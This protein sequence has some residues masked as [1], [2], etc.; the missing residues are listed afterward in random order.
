MSTVSGNYSTG[1][2]STSSTTSTSTGVITGSTVIP[3]PYPV[4]Y[5]EHHGFV[6]GI[7]DAGTTFNNEATTP[8]TLTNGATS[9]SFPVPGGT[10]HWEFVNPTPAPPP[11][12]VPSWLGPGLTTFSALGE[13]YVK[14]GVGGQE[15]F[16]YLVSSLPKVTP[17][18]TYGAADTIGNGLGIGLAINNFANGNDVSAWGNIGET[19]GGIG[20][21]AIGEGIL[22]PIFSVGG[23]ALGQFI[24][25]GLANY[26]GATDAGG[27]ANTYFDPYAQH[28][29]APYS[30]FGD[31]YSLGLSAGYDS[32]GPS[33]FNDSFAQ[34]STP[35]PAPYSDFGATYGNLLSSDS[36][37]NYD[38]S[39]FSGNNNISATSGNYSDGGDF[40]Y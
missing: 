18:L 30:N 27:S 39:A 33:T 5:P 4:S 32:N 35:A 29:G 28:T 24:G 22:S 8:A 31:T 16:D 23:A 11:V 13:Q 34:Y 6:G 19:I 26:F 21:A 38:P 15:Q 3:T 14:I 1:G 7:F 20:G 37:S 2:T 10:A 12:E 25:K 17:Y 40:S 36:S 9:G